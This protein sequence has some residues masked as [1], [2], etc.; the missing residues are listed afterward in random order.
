MIYAVYG[1]RVEDMVSAQLEKSGALDMDGPFRNLMIAKT[2]YGSDFFIPIPINKTPYQ[3]LILCSMKHL[4]GAMRRGMKA[5]FH[6]VDLHGAIAQLIKRLSRS[7]GKRYD[8]TEP[9]QEMI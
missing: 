9:E 7:D 6:G 2:V 4:K 8:Y 1:N 5:E 3:A